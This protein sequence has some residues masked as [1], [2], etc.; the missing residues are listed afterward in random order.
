MVGTSIRKYPD[1]KRRKFSHFCK[2][3]TENAPCWTVAV[4]EKVVVAVVVVV[5]VVV[6][7]VAA[8]VIVILIVALVVQ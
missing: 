8:A 2:L 3:V 5:V 4:V 7:E 6:I 1:K